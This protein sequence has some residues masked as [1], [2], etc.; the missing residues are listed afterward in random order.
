LIFLIQ[1]KIFLGTSEGV[2]KSVDSGSTWQSLGPRDNNDRNIAV[3]C[4]QIDPI[5]SEVVYIGTKYF[6]IVQVCGWWIK[7]E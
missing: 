4:I 7:M 3:L 1:V 5:S 2:L 6:G